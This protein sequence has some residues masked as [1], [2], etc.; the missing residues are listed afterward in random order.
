MVNREKE[1]F[2]FL[3]GGGRNEEGM[4]SEGCMCDTRTR[5]RAEREYDEMRQLRARI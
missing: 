2:F 4:Q 5:Y 3:G 1:F